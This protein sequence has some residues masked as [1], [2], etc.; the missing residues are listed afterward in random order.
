MS[1]SAAVT[2]DEALARLA[3]PGAD[4]LAGGTDWYAAPRRG[5]PG[6]D[7]VDVASIVGLDA[8]SRGGDGW[9]I[10]AGVTWS[11]LLAAELPGAFDALKAA[12]REVGSVQ[13]QN[14]ATLVGNLCNASPAADGVPPLLALDARVELASR[15]GAR[16]LPLADFLLGPRHTARRADELVTAI[17]VPE[18]AEATVARFAKLG[19]RRYLVISI[20]MIA[21]VLEPDARGRVAT[22]RVAVGACSPVARR[23]PALERALVGRAV[24]DPALADAV[25]PERLDALAPI[26]DV[27]ASAAYRRDAVAELLRRLLAP[28]GI[29]PAT[30]GG[31]R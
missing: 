8:L 1:A 13:I 21:L 17:L 4:V 26:D 10:G 22:A 5:A 29:A 15:D 12:A 14:T 23:L 16:V 9:R 24:D 7:V 3:V 20:A 28:G 6:T 11:S 25:T 31:V 30:D 2:L 18:H 27:R 19:S